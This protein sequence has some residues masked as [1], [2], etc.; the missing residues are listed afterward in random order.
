MNNNV[1]ILFGG[2]SRE[3]LV[4]TA[5][6]QNIATALPNASCWFWDTDDKVYQIKHETLIAHENPFVKSFT[7]AN[8]AKWSTL[9]SALKDDEAKESVF[10]LAMHGGKSEDGTVQ[11]WFE[12]EK[13]VYTGSDSHSCAI[14]FDKTKAKKI[15]TPLRIRTPDSIV[16]NGSNLEKANQELETFLQ[17]HSKLAFK[18]VADGSSFG[19][20]LINN[21]RDIKKALEQLAESPNTSFLAENFISGTELTIGVIEDNGSL[22]ALP[23]TEIRAKKDR[24][25]DYNGKYLGDG[26]TETTPAEVPEAM[27]QMAQRVALSAHET[28]NCRGYSRTDT[29]V[30]EH[31][32]VFLETNTLPGLSKASLVPQ[33]LAINGISM[34]T[35]LNEQISIALKAKK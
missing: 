25:F 6:A 7:P 19:F 21:S 34:R 18:P 5:T 23:C 28:F 3:R 24:I 2:E 8:E 13:I 32:P 4:S 17:K 31:G 30:D 10:I 14:T 16:V 33:Q 12:D 20:L 11:K 26:V 1:I 27:A 9:K 15:I 29:I 35:F 22:I